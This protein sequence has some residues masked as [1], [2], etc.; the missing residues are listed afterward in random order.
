MKKLKKISTKTKKR[1]KNNLS[2]RYR[3]YKREPLRL[4]FFN[5]VWQLVLMLRLKLS[6]NPSFFL[7]LFLL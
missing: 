4:P 1:T 3:N 2:F 6:P 5:C 7:S